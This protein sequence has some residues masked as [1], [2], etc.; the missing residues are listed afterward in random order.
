[1]HRYRTDSVQSLRLSSRS[2][3]SHSSVEEVCAC[4]CVRGDTEIS[5]RELPRLVK[6]CEGDTFNRVFPPPAS[7][8]PLLPLTVTPLDEDDKKLLSTDF[9]VTS[10]VDFFVRSG[11]TGLCIDSFSSVSSSSRPDFVSGKIWLRG[12][13]RFFSPFLC[14]KFGFAPI[15]STEK[16]GGP[17][18]LI[19]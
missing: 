5:S 18:L 16:A 19:I 2:C 13:E 3:R 1:M 12:S 17:V 6:L 10:G 7:P 8:S 15:K 9:R 11:A 14:E 4:G